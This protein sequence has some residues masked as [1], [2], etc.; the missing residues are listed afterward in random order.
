MGLF[1]WTEKMSVGIG[2]IDKEHI[3]LFD[4][5]NKIHEGMMAGKGQDAL[6]TVI[7]SLLD[8]TKF[9]FGNEEALLRQ[10]GFPGLTE[11]IKLHEGFKTK[12]ADL[13]NKLKNGSPALAIPTLDFLQEWLVKHIQGVDFQ[14]KGFLAAKGVK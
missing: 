3:Q 8:Y 4:I 1:N 2:K 7:N 10:H 14:Y 5:M 6:S 13:N 9:H 12:V 11:H